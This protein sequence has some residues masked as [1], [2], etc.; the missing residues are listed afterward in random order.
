VARRGNRH[1]HFQNPPVSRGPSASAASPFRLRKIAGAA[2]DHA[3]SVFAARRLS[4]SGGASG[5][6]TC[7]HPGNSV[8]MLVGGTGCGPIPPRHYRWPVR[9]QT[10]NAESRPTNASRITSIRIISG[11]SFPLPMK[12]RALP[13]AFSFEAQVPLEPALHVPRKAYTVVHRRGN[14][15]S[16]FQNLPVSR[17]PSSG[18]ASQF[19]L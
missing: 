17:G 4:G 12:A 11:S 15:H 9:V 19:R 8:M 14:R 5:K 10:I 1:A 3:R 16:D 2:C 6:E 7:R 18:A 13:R